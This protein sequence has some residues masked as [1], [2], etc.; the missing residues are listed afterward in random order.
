MI[1]GYYKFSFVATLKLRIKET[2]ITITTQR[3]TKDQKSKKKIKK[4]INTK[5]KIYAAIHI[6]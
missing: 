5:V 4:I 2:V 3:S 6:T 1:F